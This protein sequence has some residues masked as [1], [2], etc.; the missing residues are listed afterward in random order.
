MGEL[1]SSLRR[2]LDDAIE[3]LPFAARIEGDVVDGNAVDVL[4]EASAALD[5]LVVGS[6]GYGAMRAVMAG[7]ITRALASQC[8]CPLLVVPRGVEHPLESM[9]SGHH[10][11]AR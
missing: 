4:V 8:R 5:L 6:R 3:R 7:T 2:G 1:R 11:A 9:P 10:S